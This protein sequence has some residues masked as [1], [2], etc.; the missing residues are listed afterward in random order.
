M[1][2]PKETDHAASGS[3]WSGR[4]VSSGAIF[5]FVCFGPW[6]SFRERSL[7]APW[8]GLE[9]HVHNVPGLRDGGS[10][11]DF[12]TMAVY[13][14]AQDEVMDWNKVTVSEYGAL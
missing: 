14:A 8:D 2:G 4:A 7:P 10:K 11:K 6:D 5:L 3:P 9:M 13:V 1:A 12:R